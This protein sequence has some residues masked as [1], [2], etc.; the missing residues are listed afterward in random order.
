MF[1][2]LTTENETETWKSHL[3]ELGICISTFLSFIISFLFSLHPIIID[4]SFLSFCSEPVI[5]QP[6]KMLARRNTAIGIMQTKFQKKF[7]HAE[8]VDF[9][10]QEITDF[11][12][13]IADFPNKEISVTVRQQNE[14]SEKPH[15]D[16]HV[17]PREKPPQVLVKNHITP[18]MAALII[19]RAWRRHIVSLSQ[20]WSITVAHLCILS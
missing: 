4:I 9:S 20:Y 17:D 14:P 3:H 18:F 19:Q 2:Y 13:E 5:A 10:H 6:K 11:R 8:N 16:H 1:P 12:K 15:G 7:L